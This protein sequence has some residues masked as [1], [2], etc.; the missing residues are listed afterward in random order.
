MP[1]IKEFNSQKCPHYGGGFACGILHNTNGEVVELCKNCPNE[2]LY[3]TKSS[4]KTY[5]GLPRRKRKC[6]N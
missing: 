4:S 1:K 3:C 6:P 2:D 5:K